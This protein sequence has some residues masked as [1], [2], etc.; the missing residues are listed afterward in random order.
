MSSQDM[1]DRFRNAMAPLA[2]S[3]TVVTTD[4]AKGK[5]GVTVSTMCSLSL[6]PPSVV[7]C[8]HN[9]SQALEPIVGNGHFSANV[10]SEDQSRV[11]MAFAGQIEEYRDDRFASAE[12]EQLVTGAPVLKGAMAAFDCNLVDTKPFGSH[13]ILIGEVVEVASQAVSPLV[14]S[15]RSFKKLRVA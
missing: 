3:V 9:M 13:V 8:V 10:L 12:W 7:V 14:Y 5:A 1:P 11:A 15:D 4:G 2:S 6:E